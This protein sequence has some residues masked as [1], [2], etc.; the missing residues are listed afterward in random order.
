MWQ[1]S[2]CFGQLLQWYCSV[3]GVVQ[4]CPL[5]DRPLQHGTTCGA[6]CKHQLPYA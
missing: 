1:T 3:P 2:G 5:R 6:S 4:S